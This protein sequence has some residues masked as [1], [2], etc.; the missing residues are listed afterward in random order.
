VDTHILKILPD[1]DISSM[2]QSTNIQ[3]TN[4]K[5]HINITNLHQQKD[6]NEFK[7]IIKM[8]GLINLDKIDINQQEKMNNSFQNLH[9]KCN[10]TNK[11]N[12]Y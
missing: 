3:L 11:C 12:A 2:F 4:S 9:H 5:H 10:H 8:V 6:C 7:H 1:D